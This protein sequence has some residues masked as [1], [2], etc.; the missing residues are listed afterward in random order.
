MRDGQISSLTPKNEANWHF[1]KSYPPY[2]KFY[3]IPQT[4]YVQAH[5]HTQE[6]VSGVR[7]RWKIAVFPAAQL[8][9][10]PN[11][12]IA[13]LDPALPLAACVSIRPENQLYKGKVTDFSRLSW[14]S[15]QP[16]IS[17]VKATHTNI[18]CGAPWKTEYF[19]P[20]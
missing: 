19:S 17:L 9:L 14:A 1:S 16:S 4:V 5:P 8:H 10:F 12:C 18:F 6:L 3:R 13:V 11:F 20:S 7:R 15:R 2:A